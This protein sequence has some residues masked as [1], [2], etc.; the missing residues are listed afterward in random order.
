MPELQPQRISN[1]ATVLKGKSII[2]LPLEDLKTVLRVCMVKIGLRANNWPN[3]LER[4]ILLEHIH[5]NYG[6]HTPE[7]IKLAFDMAILGSLDCEVNCYENFSCLYFSQ[8]MNAYRK[9][10][11]EEIKLVPEPPQQRLEPEW[12]LDLLIAMNKQNELR[13]KLLPPLK[14]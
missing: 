5:T 7:E 12:Y 3:D 14:F 2:N 1:L 11:R 10:A 8:V 6:N 9:W 13:R 4:S